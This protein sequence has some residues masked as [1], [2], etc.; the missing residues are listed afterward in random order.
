[1]VSLK[2]DFL[3]FSNIN[4]LSSTFNIF[5]LF[6][7]FFVLPK[8]IYFMILFNLVDCLYIWIEICNWISIYFYNADFFEN[9]CICEDS[10][11]YFIKSTNKFSKKY[12]VN[13]NMKSHDLDDIIQRVYFLLYYSILFYLSNLKCTYKIKID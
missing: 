1:M 10:A 7:I 6:F 11:I 8:F 3:I 2:I 4:N 12:N 13:I 5:F 9:T